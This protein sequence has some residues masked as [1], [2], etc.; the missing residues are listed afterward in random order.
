MSVTSTLTAP[1][2]HRVRRQ[3]AQTRRRG[4]VVS[5]QLAVTTM[6]SL[7]RAAGP[8]SDSRYLRQWA[9]STATRRR[10]VVA[11]S[12]AATSVSDLKSLSIVVT[13]AGHTST[14]NPPPQRSDRRAETTLIGVLDCSLVSAMIAPSNES[15]VLRAPDTGR[16]NNAVAMVTSTRG[17]EQSSVQQTPTTAAPPVE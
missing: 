4:A 12:E 14:L 10:G 5:V 6:M 1:A 7:T 13:P 11:T 16:R 2:T 17:A 15:V 9:V 8:A 3:R